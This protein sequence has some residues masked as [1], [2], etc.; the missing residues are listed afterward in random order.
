MNESN[1]RNDEPQ[2]PA[3][4]SDERLVARA[5]AGDQGALSTLLARHEDR[6]RRIARIRMGRR[7]RSFLESQDVVQNS[8]LVATQQLEKF[9][10][11]GPGSFV[12][13]LSRIVENQV[14]DAAK[15]AGAVKRDPDRVVPLD[16]AG[17]SSRRSVLDPPDHGARPSEIAMDAELRE[18]FDAC[19]AALP[20]DMREVVLLRDYANED[21]E[22][23]AAKLE[24]SSEGAIRQLYRRARIK[25]GNALA[26]RTG[27]AK[28]AR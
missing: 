3:D 25:L 4:E 13:W 28:E 27:D 1:Q 22:T 12:A 20:A 18:A 2:P 15:Y 11:Q 6:A 5:V 19:V 9:Q 24:R 7:V 21:W 14:R 26:Q 8:L 16:L 17:A 23:I 10:G